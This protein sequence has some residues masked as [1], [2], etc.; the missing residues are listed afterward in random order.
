MAAGLTNKQFY[1]RVYRRLQRTKRELA[2]AGVASEYHNGALVYQEP[3]PIGR[4][5]GFSITY[6][7]LNA[8]NG[9]TAGLARIYLVNDSGERE[10]Y[11]HLNFSRGIARI[12]ELYAK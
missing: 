3:A 6:R 4:V 1:N 8:S 2:Q 12:K 5:V 9:E 7:R 10:T 11:D